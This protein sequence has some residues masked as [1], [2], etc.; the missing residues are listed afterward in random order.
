MSFLF[1]K[2]I[3]QSNLISVGSNPKLELPTPS[4]PIR[5]IN[6]IQFHSVLFENGIELRLDSIWTNPIQVNSIPF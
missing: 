6:S 2:A 5:K 1:F 3:I 4:D